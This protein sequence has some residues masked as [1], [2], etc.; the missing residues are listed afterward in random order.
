MDKNKNIA[1]CGLD[2]EKCEAYTATLTDDDGMRANVA[3]KWS[4]LN[5]V[6]ITPEMINCEGCRA[7]GAKTVYCE[8]LCEIRKC[9]AGKGYSTCGCC[10]DLENCEKV[11]AVTGNNKDALSNL[12]KLRGRAV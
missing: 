11:G 12:M 10:G 7:D 6:E 3:K 4:E 9:A 1:Y 5:G 8:S 2:C